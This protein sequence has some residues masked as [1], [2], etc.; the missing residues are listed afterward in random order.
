MITKIF[1]RFLINSKT[2]DNT[3]PTLK[4]FYKEKFDK[5]QWVDLHFICAKFIVDTFRESTT[6]ENDCR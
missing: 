1:W 3:S 4:R 5:K 6:T 2:L